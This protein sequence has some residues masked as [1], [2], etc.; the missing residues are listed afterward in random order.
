M[1]A[2]VDNRLRLIIFISIIFVGLIP[3]NLGLHLE[4]IHNFKSHAQ[5]ALKK[6]LRV[7]FRFIAAAIVTTLEAKQAFEGIRIDTNY[8]YTKLLTRRS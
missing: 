3:P 4:P 6:R 8:P 2:D 5:A 7:K 1:V